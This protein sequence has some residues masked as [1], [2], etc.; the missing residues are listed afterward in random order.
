M[1]R[2]VKCLGIAALVVVLSCLFVASALAQGWPWA[3]INQDGFGTVQNQSVTSLLVHGGVLYAGTANAA[4]GAEVWAYSSGVWAASSIAGWGAGAATPAAL[5]MASYGGNLYAGTAGASPEVWMFNGAIW[6]LS[7]APGGT[8]LAVT[9][10]ASYG[11]NLYAGTLN[12][13]GGAELWWFNGTVWAPVMTGGLTT[14][15]SPT[16]VD[17]ITALHVYN[18]LLY[19]GT[20]G[21]VGEA[22]LWAYNGATWA[23]VDA[24]ALAGHTAIGDL[25]TYQSSLAIAADDEVWLL[26]IL[27]LRMLEDFDDAIAVSQLEPLGNLLVAAVEHISRGPVVWAFDGTGWR[28][29]SL[30]GFG[31]VDNL[32]MTAMTVDGAD[33]YV[34]T[35][36]FNDG[37]EVW[38]Q[39]LVLNVD[40]VD[41]HDPLCSGWTQR[42]SIQ[43]HNTQNYTLTGVVLTDTLPPRTIPLLD[44]ST[45]GATLVVAGVVQWNL[46]RLGPL[47]TRSLYFEIHTF[48]NIP[49]GTVI[50]NTVFAT[51]NEG[52]S[53]WG[54]AETLMQWCAPPTSTP[55]STPT[56]TNTPTPT[57]THT[58]TSTASPTATPTATWTPTPTATATATETPT[59]TGTPGPSPTSTSTATNTPTPTATRYAASVAGLVWNDADL[60]GVF[61]I[62]ESPLAG[63]RVQIRTLQGE[64]VLET[65]PTL[66]D[67]RYL[68]PDVE[69]GDYLLVEINPRGYFST[70]PDEVAITLAPRGLALVDFGDARF[71]RLYIPFTYVVKVG[72]MGWHAGEFGLADLTRHAD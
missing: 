27:G 29:T 52:V 55:T 50:T 13:T 10:L 66:D 47:E 3:Q 70:T 56:R 72:T 7:L 43:V 18:G 60:N 14:Q 42:Y 41:W 38:S 16:A 33:I 37:G 48:S 36:N 39:A 58:P 64:V 71:W 2:T 69:P 54:V 6:T 19:A 31:D 8:N 1:T 26:D 67:G 9:S 25:C 34:G 5:S 46:D 44:N 53:D 24:G 40:K 30:P 65:G 12:P 23:W 21:V 61:D 68:F 49:D 15:G 62:G 20:S 22:Q 51:A 11:G 35:H 32:D 45:P 28:E 4:A 57:A 17:A 63:A 59:A